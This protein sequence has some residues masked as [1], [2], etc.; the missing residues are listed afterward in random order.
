MIFGITLC[1][2]SLG[3]G[4]LQNRMVLE[5]W[6]LG[7]CKSLSRPAPASGGVCV[8]P[9]A[10]ELHGCHGCLP[11]WLCWLAGW[12]AVLAVLPAWLPGWL[13]GWLALPAVQMVLGH[14]A[15]VNN[16]DSIRPCPK[17]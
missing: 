7:S 15:N 5:L 3:A 11:G 10:R 14:E 17:K 6:E 2:S 13:P 9:V 16:L 8:L 4:I 1:R 12:L